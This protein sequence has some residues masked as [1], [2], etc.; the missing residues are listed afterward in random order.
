[1][2]D[3]HYIND[4]FFHKLSEKLSLRVREKT[5]KYL[6]NYFSLITIKLCMAK[7]FL[8]SN[9]IIYRNE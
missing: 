2:S 6:I 4:K 1:M 9:I 7:L 3:Y 8:L 5:F